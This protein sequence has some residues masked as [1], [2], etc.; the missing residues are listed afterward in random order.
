MVG[1]FHLLELE[2]LAPSDE[3]SPDQLIGGN[4]DKNDC[5]DS[6]DQ[7]THV[8]GVS[9]RLDIAA[10]AGK[11][12]VGAVERK[13][14]AGHQRKPAVGDGDDGVPHQ[15]DRRV[16]HFELPETLPRRIAINARGLDHL[17]R[18]AFHRRVKAEGEIPYLAGEDEE[19]DAHLDAKLMMRNQRNH[20]QQHR[21]QKA[22]NRN[23]LQDVQN[24]DHPCLNACIVC[25][26]IA[27]ANRKDQAEKVCDRDAR[28]RVQSVERQR[29]LRFQ[30]S[31]RWERPCQAS[32]QPCARWP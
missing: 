31:E 26:D 5:G 14:L 18:Y 7:C 25:C 27:V 23:G 11:L 1:R 9:R 13:H 32:T 19:N 10:Q 21:R 20:R 3:R 17:A 29:A 15:A 24:R 22:E 6:T 12:E 28:H 2:L 8:A 16:G 30:R 4:H